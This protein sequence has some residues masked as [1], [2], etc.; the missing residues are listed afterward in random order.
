MNGDL[1]GF[2]HACLH[3][4]LDYLPSF[5]SAFNKG[6]LLGNRFVTVYVEIALYSSWIAVVSEH[7]LLSGFHPPLPVLSRRPELSVQRRTGKLQRKRI[8][9]S[10]ARASP[11]LLSG[12]MINSSTPTSTRSTV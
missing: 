10:E 3:V 8:L 11:P 9:A 4:D 12:V 6:A 5:S 7:Y 1:E 2:C